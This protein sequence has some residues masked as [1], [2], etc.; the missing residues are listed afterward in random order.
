MKKYYLA[1]LLLLSLAS[2]FEKEEEKSTKS[3]MC[4]EIVSSSD[5][6]RE[7]LINKCTGDT[8]AMVADP[9]PKEN[10][11]QVIPPRTYKWYKINRLDVE[12]IYAGYPNN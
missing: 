1:L 3:K 8:W 11:S 2:C 9:Y 12:N 5:T 7:I 10:K 6:P 4:F